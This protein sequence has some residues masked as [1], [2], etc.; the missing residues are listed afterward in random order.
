MSGTDEL[1][2][3]ADEH[4]ARAPRRRLGIVALVAALLAVLGDLIAAG[5]GYTTLFVEGLSDDRIGEIA[6]AVLVVVLIV[7]L[8]L[9]LALVALALGIAAAVTHRAPRP[10]V[11]GAVLGGVVALVQI[12]AIAWFVS[13]SN[14]LY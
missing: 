11:V 8:D 7:G 12:A 13:A 5:T 14:A 3:D 2:P 1:F 10:G 4:I 9:V 6:V